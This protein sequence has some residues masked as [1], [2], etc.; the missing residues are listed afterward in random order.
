M[1]E[2]ISDDQCDGE[3]VRIMQWLGFQHRLASARSEE[4][5]KRLKQESLKQ[6]FLRL[7][8]GQP[9]FENLFSS[10]KP[11]WKLSKMLSSGQ[12]SVN[13]NIICLWPLFQPSIISICFCSV[14]PSDWWHQSSQGSSGWSGKLQ[15]GGQAIQLVKDWT[16]L[17]SIMVNFFKKPCHLSDLSNRQWRGP[18]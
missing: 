13:I 8:R 14:W 3:I 16:Y 10:C 2:V 1:F 12:K 17:S 9:G 4:C 18:W 11:V 7:P 6:K 15:E 5:L